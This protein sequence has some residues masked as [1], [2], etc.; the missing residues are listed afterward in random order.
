[1][2]FRIPKEIPVIYEGLPEKG[3]VIRGVLKK[4]A[5]DIS[6]RISSIHGFLFEVW[7]K[8]T[9]SICYTYERNEAIELFCDILEEGYIQVFCKETQ[10][11]SYYLYDRAVTDSQKGRYY[12]LHRL[13][14]GRYR[15]EFDQETFGY[16]PGHFPN[17]VKIVS[18]NQEMM[19]GYDLGVVYGY[20]NQEIVLPAKNIVKESFSVIIMHK[21]DKGEQVYDFVRPSSRKKGELQYTLME[22][23]GI[24]VITD[25]ADFIDAKIFLGGCAVSNGD[26]GNIRTGSRFLSKGYN[27]EIVFS[28]PVEGKGGCYTETIAQVRQ[29]FIKDLKVHYTAVEAQDY[30]QLVRTTPMLCIDKV[31]AVRDTMKNQVKIAVKPLSPVPFPRLSETYK[32]AIRER[33][34]QARLLTV[35]IEIEQPVYV[36]V[37]VKGTI[38]IKPHYTG[39]RQQIEDVIRRELDY[40]ST[41]RNFGE[42][43]HFDTLFHRIEELSCVKYIYELSVTAQNSM[44][45]VQKGLDMYPKHYCLLYPE[46]IILDLNTTE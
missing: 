46:E 27:S 40:I 8:E 45:V 44:H 17:A 19:Y 35:N 29:R 5:Y 26:Q 20:D 14:F 34:E 21:N 4:A 36:P 28:N 43:F 18:Y 11:G 13:G 39:S 1:L 30:E 41:N 33:L 9:K 31:K 22:N 2:S 10:E 25:A 42:Q 3:Y 37:Y 12:R 38:Y 7:Q 24:L 16:M 6:P 15:I 23:D 32:K